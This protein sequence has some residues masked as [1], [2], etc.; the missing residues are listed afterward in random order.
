AGADRH[1]WTVGVVF[2]EDRLLPWLTV[3]HNVE[4][5]LKTRGLDAMERRAAAG[6]Y[7]QMVGLGGFEDYYPGRVSGGR[8]QRAAIA[9]VLVVEPDILPMDEPLG[10]PGAQNP[11]TMQKEV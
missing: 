10:A 6:R 3:R 7:L 5:V 1:R 2:Q 8:R 9:R 11:R 4:L